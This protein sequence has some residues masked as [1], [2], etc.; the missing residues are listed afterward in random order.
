MSSR[1][2]ADLLV[3]GGGILGAFHAYHAINRGF[4]VILI[5]RDSRPRG[6]TVRNFGQIVPSGMDP[7]WQ[8]YGRESLKIYQALQNRCDLTVKMEGSIYLASNQDELQLLEELAT[9]NKENSYRSE[10]WTPE[11]CRE[12]YPQLRREYCKGGLFFPDEISVNPRQM[13]HRVH[14]LLSKCVNF[15][16]HFNTS[17]KECSVNDNG[18]VV[19]VTAENQKYNAR[20]AIICSGHDLQTLFPDVYRSSDLQLVQLQMLRT[21]PLPQVLVPG[22]V[23][24][25]LTIRRYESFH[26]CP[27]WS[28]IRSRWQPDPFQQ[29]F[30]IHLLFKQELDGSMIVGD[31]HQ[32][33]EARYPDDLP[34]G[35]QTVINEYMLAKAQEIFS[36]PSWDLEESWTGIYSQTSDIKGYFS[37][38]IDNHIHLLT[39][40]GGKGMTAGPGFAKA[41][42]NEVFDD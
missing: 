19:A 28:D 17:V 35:Q 31:S 12:R 41:Y 10:L 24:T 36:L 15:V 16:S 25:G 33:T 9:I 20:R 11:K 40:I 29:Q 34:L 38:R 18:V 32:Y 30:G 2:D 42:L 37:H 23:L 7:H 5:E 22:N 27:S 13:I 14:Q 6:A 39:G 3:I 26:Q 8:Q 21:R 4:R 1:K